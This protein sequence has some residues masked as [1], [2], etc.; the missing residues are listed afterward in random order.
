[1]PVV[2]EGFTIDATVMEEHVGESD[3]TD[4]PVESGSANT[5]HIRNHPRRLVLDCVVSDTPI[6][7]IAD[8]R[9]AEGSAAPSIDAREYLELVRDNRETVQVRTEI[10]TYERM[11]LVSLSEPRRSDTGE[12]MRFTATFKVVEIATNGRSI[13]RV[14]A[15]RHARKRNLGH[16][17]APEAT[18]PASAVPRYESALVTVGRAVGAI[19]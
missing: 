9:A 1:M 12:A 16:K 17:P 5:E 7:D 4:F 6:G 8:L 11:A 19:D 3:V 15:P 10:R 14:A 2:I 18:P 13:V